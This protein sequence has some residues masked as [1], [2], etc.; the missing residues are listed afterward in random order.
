MGLSECIHASSA[1]SEDFVQSI[2]GTSNSSLQ[3]ALGTTNEVANNLLY[4]SRTSNNNF[5]TYAQE[6][7]ATD[8]ATSQVTQNVF[9]SF[10]FVLY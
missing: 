2:G 1:Q 5:D 4:S 3:N 10:I 9:I 6:F 7:S 8:D